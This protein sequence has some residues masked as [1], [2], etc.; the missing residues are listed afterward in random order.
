MA[1]DFSNCQIDQDTIVTGSSDG[2]I[3]ILS[4]QPNKVIGILGEHV[5]GLPVEKIDIDATSQSLLSLSHSN[6]VKVWGIKDLL[7]D[8]D[9]EEDPDS[10]GS[11]VD[12][13]TEHSKAKRAKHAG[14]MKGSNKSLFSNV[15]QASRSAFFS[16]L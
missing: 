1:I 16:D 8:N 10:D 5:Q 9:S 3:R 12:S 4:V 15:E 11:E 7:E 2:L 6:T 14:K 13:E